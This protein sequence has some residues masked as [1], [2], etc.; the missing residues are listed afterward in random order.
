MYETIG[1]IQEE[2]FNEESGT[3]ILWSQIV[4]KAEEAGNGAM[5][6]AV[7]SSLHHGDLVDFGSYRG[8][9]VFLVVNEGRSARG[10][11]DWLLT[12]TLG[13]MGYCITPHFHD[14]PWGYFSTGR[15]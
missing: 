7:G 8:T 2:L 1:K 12:K 10:E 6:K 13:E 14:A 9:G 3:E 11:K 15:L 4:E 5:V